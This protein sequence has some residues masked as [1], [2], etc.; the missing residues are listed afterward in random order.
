MFHQANNKALGNGVDQT[1]E[2]EVVVEEV[3]V[4]DGKEEVVAEADLKN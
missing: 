4:E 2:E 1:I 3:A